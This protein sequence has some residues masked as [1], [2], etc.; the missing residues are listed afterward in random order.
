L[1]DQRARVLSH[2][3]LVEETTVALVRVEVQQE[4]EVHLHHA[5]I[6]LRLCHLS[7]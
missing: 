6:L 5:V 1:N 3:L 2:L 7:R 4:G